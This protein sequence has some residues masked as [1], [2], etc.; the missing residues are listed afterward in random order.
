MFGYNVNV[1]QKTEARKIKRKQATA[2]EET[3]KG[4]AKRGRCGIVP[5]L[6]RKVYRMSR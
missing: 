5:K 6:I 4:E 2:A 3:L 1:L